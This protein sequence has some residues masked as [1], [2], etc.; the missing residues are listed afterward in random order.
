MQHS[1]F[2]PGASRHILYHRKNSYYETVKRYENVTY[3]EFARVFCWFKSD[4]VGRIATI[5]IPTNARVHSLHLALS[6]SDCQY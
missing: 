1:I 2:F 4:K 6:R 3:Q 5:H